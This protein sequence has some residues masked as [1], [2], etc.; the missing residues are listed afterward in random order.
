MTVALLVVPMA[1]SDS[2]TQGQSTPSA[3]AAPAPT[4]TSTTGD[5]A[6][7]TDLKASLQ[8]LMN[9]KPLQDG[10]TALNNAMA[11][12]KSSLVGAAASASAAL[13]PAVASVKAAFSDVET[14]ASGLTAENFRE[15]APAINTALRQVGTAASSFATTLTQTCPGS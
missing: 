13:Q 8:T 14:A 2:S 1:C 12:V 10:L 11:G 15:K 5:C 4:G 9:V 3:T 7:V 6:A